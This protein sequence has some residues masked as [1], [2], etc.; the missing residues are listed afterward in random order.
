MTSKQYLLD[1]NVLIEFLDGTPS[2]VK[3]VFGVGLHN[4]CI[5]VITLHELYYGAYLAKERKEEYFEKEIEKINK[6][7]EKFTVLELSALG[8]EYGFVKY[9]LKSK[10]EMIDDFDLVIA[11]QAI[12]E[13]LIVVTDNTKHFNRIPG[14]SIVNW[15]ER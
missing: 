4:C 10:G 8:K 14:L 13:N 3:H 7:L 15:M 12:S 5:S 2:V 1:T 11:G 6:L 9:N